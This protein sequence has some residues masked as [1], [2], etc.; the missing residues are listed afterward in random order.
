MSVAAKVGIRTIRFANAIVNTTVLIA[1]LLLLAF[2]GYAVWDSNQVHQSAASVLYEIY[3]PTAENEGISFAQLQAINSDVFGWLTVYGTNIDYPIVQSLDN[4]KYINTNAMGDY[5]LSGAIFADHRN[6]RDFSDFNTIFYGHHMEK[7][8]M[9][10]EIGLFA[11]RGF[12]NERQYGMLFYDGQEHGLE[13][14][15]FLH[16]DAY[17]ET[18]FQAGVTEPGEQRE[19][20]D[21]MISD[22]VHFREGVSVTID[23]RI[24]LLSTCSASSTNGRDILVGR[25]TGSIYDDPFATTEIERST[26]IAVI[27]HLSSLFTQTP[28]WVVIVSMA[29]LGMVLIILAVVIT[30]SFRKGTRRQI[31]QRGR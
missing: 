21:E 11:E 23:D 3:K 24:V 22:A 7:Q 13:L 31:R 14:F 1:I 15:A 20:I 27:D 28:L 30:K 8:T 26:S 6:S 16:V 2:A 9:F 19:Y 4:V 18:I 17:N 10:G 12:F 29:V 5:S 25:I